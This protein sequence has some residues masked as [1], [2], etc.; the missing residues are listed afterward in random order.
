MPSQRAISERDMRI[1]KELGISRERHEN[2]N[3]ICNEMPTGKLRQSPGDDT[4]MY[5]DDAG[6]PWR[7]NPDLFSSFHQP[8]SLVNAIF[9]SLVDMIIFCVDFPVPNM[10]FISLNDSDGMWSEIICNRY[11]GELIVDPAYFGTSNFCTDAP[12]AMSSGKLNTKEH[13]LWDVKTHT[14]YG[15]HGYKH[16]AKGIP[17]GYYDGSRPHP[18]VLHEPQGGPKAIYM[19]KE[20]DPQDPSYQQYQSSL[21]LEAEQN[22]KKKQEEEEQTELPSATTTASGSSQ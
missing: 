21:L 19:S 13:V 22:K 11:T 5:V 15:W 8:L 14:K 9:H 4:M 6:R 1:H 12:D 10:K 16:I 18:V 3:D 17:C 2:R 20:N 7:R